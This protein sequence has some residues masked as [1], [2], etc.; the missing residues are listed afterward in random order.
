MGIHANIWSEAS[1]SV[2]FAERLPWQKTRNGGAGKGSEVNNILPGEL[3]H[4]DAALREIPGHLDVRE[5]QSPTRVPGACLPEIALC[6]WVTHYTLQISPGVGDHGRG[7]GS[8][9][10][11]QPLF[12]LFHRRSPAASQAPVSRVSL[13]GRPMPGDPSPSSKAITVFP[14]QTCY[15]NNSIHRHTLTLSS[16]SLGDF[17]F[18]S[19]MHWAFTLSE[20]K[21]KILRDKVLP[22]CLGLHN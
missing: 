7:E 5:L 20:A 21:L 10:H 18:F 14:I 3:P 16:V 22:V 8:S 12:L 11:T 2:S 15:L 1:A 19:K 13:Q 4:P 6:H 9:V 17:F